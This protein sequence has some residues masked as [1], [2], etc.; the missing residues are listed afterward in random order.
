MVII[1]LA[2]LVMATLP[3]QA[4]AFTVNNTDLYLV[5]SG[6]PT[7]EYYYDLGTIASVLSSGK[8]INFSNLVGGTQWS[9]VGNTNLT[10]GGNIY[11]TS[12][13]PNAATISGSPALS[14]VGMDSIFAGFL[15][16]NTSGTA[17]VDFTQAA[18]S[19]NSY[20][21]NL[22]ISGAFG[23]NLPISV[24]A[25]NTGM[26]QNFPLTVAGQTQTMNLYTGVVSTP[27][28]QIATFTN[29]IATITNLGG[30]N[31]TSY[32]LTIASAVPLP[33]S[34][35]MFATGLIALGLIARRR[36]VGF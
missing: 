12:Q 28:N 10:T 4:K 31:G 29:M 14:T 8:T 25:T 3:N 36:Q 11:Y 27:A 16:G 2:L 23:G 6:G 5:V 1:G 20:A 35:V 30:K 7:N 13:S 18:T 26:D 22:G 17:S 19:L 32:T 34:L 15:T 24:G 9:L 21:S 33:P